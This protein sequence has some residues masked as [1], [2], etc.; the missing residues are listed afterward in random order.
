MRIFTSEP[1]KYCACKGKRVSRERLG[2]FD[3]PPS[4]GETRIA[5]AIVIALFAAFLLVLPFRNTELAEVVA[6]VPTIDAVMF[7]GELIIATMLYAQAAIFRSRALLVLASGY[8]FTA[9]LL[10][11]HALAF[12]GAFGF[13]GLLGG[14]NS[15]AW[16]MILRRWA[17]PVAVILYAIFA[18]RDSDAQ[19]DAERPR[20]R[21]QLWVV[22]TIGV[23]AAAI[24]LV[25]KGDPLL[26]TMFVNRRDVLFSNLFLTNIST[27]ATALVA[28]VAL[29]VKRRSVLDLWLLV[30]SAAWLIQ[31]LVNL[32]LHA[33]FTVGWYSLYLLMLTS[34]VIVLIALIAESNRL[35]ARLILSTAALRRERDTRM[36]SMDAVA[37][38]I[39]HEIGQPLTAVTLHASASL[40]W[41]TRAQPDCEKAIGSLRDTID[42]GR[43]TFEVIKSIRATFS[44]GSGSLTEL[45]LNNLARETS[46]LLNG[47]LAAH[48]ILLQLELDERLA[49]AMANRV[50]IQ[51][52]LVNLM[53]NAIESI[54]APKRRDRKIAIR[55]GTQDGQN[56]LLEISDTGEGISPEQMPYIFDPFFTTKSSGTGLGL[57][58]SRSIAEEHGGRLWASSDGDGATFHL[59]LPAVSQA[60]H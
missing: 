46:A 41:L 1:A 9:L 43:R 3:T 53:T 50:Q 48:R 23:A 39:S 25:T 27:I 32:P 38:A 34:H 16:S 17:F 52:V 6:F 33:R 11:P 44:K 51:R 59:Q 8:V 10:I 18:S 5:A 37:A 60:K 40:K 19:P 2:L 7:V 36:M 49:P 58:L 31:G 15:S 47:E 24:V 57:S 4:R 26:P 56:V 35:Y 22:T 45:N 14:A 13:A 20:A 55:S 54:G 30:A 12:P 21:I 29:F 28:I 42:A